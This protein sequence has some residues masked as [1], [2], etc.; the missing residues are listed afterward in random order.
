MPLIAGF[1]A[2]VLTK[3]RRAEEVRSQT[4][5]LATSFSRIR[6]TLDDP[7]PGD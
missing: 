7:S 3:R 1:I 6:Y 5:E 2:D 4:R